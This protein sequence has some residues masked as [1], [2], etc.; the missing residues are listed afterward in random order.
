MGIPV[1]L[2]LAGGMG[3]CMADPDNARSVRIAVE[4][5]DREAVRAALAAHPDGLE[6]RDEVGSTPLIIATGSGQ[7]AIAE[8]LIDAGAN[9]WALD[10]FGINPA[11]NTATVKYPPGTPEGDARERVVKRLRER[12]VPFPPPPPREVLRLSKAGEWQQ[13]HGGN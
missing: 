13:P 2:G 10:R 11:G 7:F 5:R 8:L 12:G 3:A 9:V 1:A 4:Y 6:E